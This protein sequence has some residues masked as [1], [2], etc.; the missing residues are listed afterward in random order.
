MVYGGKP[1]TG[2]YLCRKRK[3]KCDEGHPGCRN[4][5]VYG[6][7]CPG[8]RPDTIFK[9][10]TGQVKGSRKG[11]QPCPAHGA[12][13][14]ATDDNPRMSSLSIYRNPGSPWEE[15]AVCF[16]FDQYTA[17]DKPEGGSHLGFIPRLYAGCQGPGAVEPASSCL[18][19]AVDA[20]ALLTLGNQ[21]KAPSLVTQARHRLALAVQGLRRALDSPVERVKDNTFAAVVILALFEDISGERNGLA[22]SHTVGFEALMKLRGESLLN[23]Q[24]L[25]MFT[26]AYVHTRI[27][28]LLLRQ[29]PRFSTRDL[30]MRL[31]PADPLQRLIMVVNELDPMSLENPLTS[32]TTDPGVITT[33][34][35]RI[36]IYRALDSELAEW[37]R[38]LPTSWL[39][40]ACRSHTGEDVLTYQ[41]QFLASIWSYYHA[42]RILLQV[43][44]LEFLQTLT[45]IVRSSG[46][47][48][49]AVRQE[50]EGSRLIQS[51]IGDTCR[52]IPFAFGAIDQLGNPLASPGA[53]QIRAFNVYHMIWPLWYILTCG[54]ATPAQAQQIRRALAEKGSEVGIK[55][56]LVLADEGGQGV[57]PLML[58]PF[59]PGSEPRLALECL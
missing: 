12:R 36:E 24:G 46:I 19:L 11:N 18:R 33:L 21:V 35:S 40:H 8:Y 23:E 17:C 49:E 53:S 52:A 48:R 10:E 34:A 14:R 56:A 43:T 9:I 26:F 5:A 29:K 30:V 27:E 3:I 7:S 25:D 22:S 13:E 32:D 4:C 6:E 15:R 54:H 2:C 37:S 45:S 38:S 1:S 58:G 50:A 55:L 51:L 39:P 42:L 31:D 59:A 16:F 41:G 44:I 47:Q 57:M 20:A 28:V